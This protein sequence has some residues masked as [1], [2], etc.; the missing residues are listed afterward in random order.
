[1]VFLFPV[2][3]ETRFK[4]RRPIDFFM[5]DIRIHNF[6][7]NSWHSLGSD[8]YVTAFFQNCLDFS[9]LS[10]YHLLIDDRCC[11]N[12][13]FTVSRTGY[14]TPGKLNNK[15]ANTSLFLRVPTPA[16]EEDRRDER[17]DE[18]STRTV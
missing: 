10:A 4:N 16:T 13:T 18:D 12:T 6:K 9:A 3:L 15:G 17:K 8:L 2:C 5:L 1:M 11:N 7:M 14:K